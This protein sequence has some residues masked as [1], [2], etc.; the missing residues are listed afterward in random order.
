MP[1]NGN[2]PAFDV[3]ADY[4]GQLVTRKY[5]T[6]DEYREGSKQDRHSVLLDYDI[7]ANVRIPD[8]NDPQRLYKPEDLDFRLKAGSAAIDAGTVLP[9][10]TDGFTGRAPDLGAYELG[11]TVPHYGPR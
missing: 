1:S 10:I 8:K 3:L 2:S 7:F 9:T 5:K 11:S 4:K 6:F